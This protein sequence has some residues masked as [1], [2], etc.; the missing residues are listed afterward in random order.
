MLESIIGDD[1][2]NRMTEA[3]KTAVV[4][5]GRATLRH[6]TEGLL[7][8]PE[9]L[10]NACRDFLINTGTTLE[11]LP[12]KSPPALRRTRQRKSASR[13]SSKTSRP[14]KIRTRRS[15]IR[16]SK[17]RFGLPNGFV[18]RLQRYGR[19]IL[20]EDNVY[21]L[22]NG[23]EFVPGHP[24]GT[25]GRIE[26]LYALLTMEQHEKGRRGSVYIR[27]DGR[28]FDYSFDQAHP[29][30]EIFETGYT[31]Q[32]LERTGRY[33]SPSGKEKTIRSAKG[34]AAPALRATAVKA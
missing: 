1:S 10:R 2:W 34:K 17:Q 8:G 26:H 6:L 13:S 14:V 29:E 23:Q 27:T 28:I 12:T 7:D 20:L 31:I 5:Q 18:P 11:G 9:Q 33:T 32:D 22:P 4:V 3:E 25:L 16:T 24:T 19:M 21:R 30:R 15:R